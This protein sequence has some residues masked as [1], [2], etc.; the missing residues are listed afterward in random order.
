MSDHNSKPSR[1]QVREPI[2]ML[3]DLTGDLL[4]PRILRAP[5]MA[6]SPSRLITGTVSAFLLTLVLQ[7]A[8]LFRSADEQASSG[9][10]QEIQT[11]SQNFNRA[12]TMLLDS[13][14][15]VD[16]MRF[17]QSIGSVILIIRD[18]VMGSPLISVIFGIPLIA[19]LSVAGSAISRSTA[20]EFAQGRFGSRQ[21]TLGYA[22]L[23]I[24]QLVGAVVG[25]IILCMVVFLIIALGGLLL[26]IPVLDVVGSILYAFA[27]VLG[28]LATIILMLHVL[29]LPMIIPSLSVEG[30]DSFD[31]IQRSYAYVIGKP[32]RYLMYLLIMIILAVLSTT[33]FAMV[34]GASIEMTDWAA[35]LYTNDSA[36]RVLSGEGELGATKGT[37]NS[38]IGIW[39]TIVELFVAGYV[40][41]IFF[42]SSTLLYLVIRRICDGQDVNEIWNGNNS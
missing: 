7:F 17:A 26:S 5:A 24:R 42:T 38:I 32:L 22:L 35:S 36:S 4:W 9:M 10:Y 40:I 16:P 41:S 34:A 13:A 6:L 8:S 19:I 33:V 25:P 28:I 14:M 21:D 27:L 37:A 3:S 15:A 12:M 29:S 39:R 20:I 1:P 11:T 23:R 18:T 30:T 31:A 2:V